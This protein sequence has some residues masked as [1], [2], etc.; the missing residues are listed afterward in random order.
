MRAN[1]TKV[2]VLGDDH[3]MMLPII[4]S[5]GRRG[6]HVHVAWCSPDNP[7]R[8]S[9]YIAQAHGLS[10]YVSGQSQ[11]LADL[12]QL[13]EQQQFDLTIPATEAAVH[14]LQ[15]HRD[16][17]VHSDRIYLLDDDAFR[18]VT[19][20]SRTSA[21]AAS[22]DIPCP[23]SIQVE[24]DSDVRSLVDQMQLPVVI[25][26]CS[27][28]RDEQQLT[29]HFVRTADTLDDAVAYLNYLAEQGADALIQQRFVGEGV[30]VELL[31]KD[32]EVLVGIQHRRLHETNGH[33]STYRETTP[34]HDALRRASEQLVEA[35]NYTGV[36]MIE[37]RIDPESGD[38]VLLEINGRFWGSLPLAVAAG[39]DF[40]SYLFE[41]LV[42]GKTEFSQAFR[43]GVRS[44][45]LTDDI[46]WMWR[47]LLGKGKSFAE[48]N[49]N[50]LGWSVNPISNSQFVKD[51]FRGLL[52]FDHIDT[53]NWTDPAPAAFELRQILASVFSGLMSRLR[54]GKRADES[55]DNSVPGLPTSAEPSI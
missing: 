49:E 29:K 5:L 46:R 24:R 55:H 15:T 41:M 36:A 18:V 4:R 16:D 20:K 40:P 27:S 19:S 1:N 28:V 47:S 51:L 13:L 21:L 42:N 17:L 7:A 44:R 38:W 30:G 39:A 35:L 25:K 43:I 48:E 34:I 23:R 2:L 12:N 31:A 11:W 32:G 52:M 45:N 14:I 26:P 3:R 6:I 8:A 9:R 54:R 37:F 53:F 33:G 50:C 10:S 22:L